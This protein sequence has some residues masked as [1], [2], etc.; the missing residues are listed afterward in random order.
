MI[1]DLIIF[2]QYPNAYA[3]IRIFE[4]SLKLGLNTKII[5]Y[6]ELPTKLPKAKFVI[7]REPNAKAQIYNLRDKIL[8]HYLTLGVK[9]LNSKSYTKWSVLD[10]LTQHIEFKKSDIPHIKLLSI[11]TAKYPFI[12]KS[13][14]GSHGD[15][16]FK[17]GN[18]DDLKSVLN[19]YSKQELIAQEFQTSGFDLRVIVLAGKALGVMKRIPQEGNFLSNYSKGATVEEYKGPD[20]KIVTDL[21]QKTAKDFKLDYVGVDLILGNDDKWKVLEVNRGCQ[22]EGFERATGINVAR[23]LVDYFLD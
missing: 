4:E 23:K 16:V 20:S 7:L 15:H 2:T 8:S 6:S 9:V 12:A 17:I 10:K 3:P 5:G 19:T 14:L 13:V 21:A 11:E 22:F 1:Y 18:K